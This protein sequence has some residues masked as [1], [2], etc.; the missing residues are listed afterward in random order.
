MYYKNTLNVQ[1]AYITPSTNECREKGGQVCPHHHK[2]VI[3]KWKPDELMNKNLLGAT[4][5]LPY[6]QDTNTLVV[7]TTYNY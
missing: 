1:L 3:V 2:K 6:N 4:S 5:A 7:S